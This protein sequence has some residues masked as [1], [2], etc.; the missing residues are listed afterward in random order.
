MAH[1]VVAHAH[2]QEVAV[3]HAAAVVV[4]QDLV[5]GVHPAAQSRV[6]AVQSHVE[7]AQNRQLKRRYANQ[8]AA[9]DQKN[10][11]HVAAIQIVVEVRRQLETPG[12]EAQAMHRMKREDHDHAIAHVQRIKM[13]SILVADHVPAPVQMIAIIQQIATKVWMIRRLQR[14][15]SSVFQITNTKFTKT[16]S[17]ITHFNKKLIFP[18]I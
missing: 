13:I 8:E 4:D 2:H 15:H 10:P 12:T 11:A 6:E 9:V 18:Y 7:A 14:L 3:A 1:V 5:Q 17:Y 16:S